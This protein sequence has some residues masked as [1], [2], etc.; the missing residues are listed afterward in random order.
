MMRSIPVEWGLLGV[1]EWDYLTN[2]Q[3]IFDFWVN[4]TIRAKPFE[5]IYTMGM[6]GNGDG[7]LARKCASTI[8]FHVDN[9]RAAVCGAKHRASGEGC[10]GSTTDLVQCVQWNRCCYHSSSLDFM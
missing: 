4:S 8:F 2:A 9:Y 3:F 1:G 6:R 5:G 7:K 10:L